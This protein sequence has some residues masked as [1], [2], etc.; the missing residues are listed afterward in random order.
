MKME[1]SPE[2]LYREREKRV[3]DAIQLKVPDRVPIFPHWGLFPAGYSGMT[4]E[5]AYYDIDN[6]LAANKKTN[7]DFAPDL[8]WGPTGGVITPGRVYEAADYKQVKW[9]GHGVSPNHSFQF[10]EGE[11]MKEDEYD[12][13]LYDPSDYA[14]RTYM[15]RVFGTLESLKMLPPVSTLIETYVL[16]PTAVLSLPEVTKAFESLYR[17]GLEA[18]KFAAAMKVFK[19]EMVELGFPLFARTVTLAP[20]DLISDKLRGMR[21]AML[22][23]YRQPDKLL[24]ACEK[25]LPM[26]I[27][28]A[29][30]GTKLYGESTV[31]IPLHRGSDGFMSL[32]QF[33]TFYWPTLKRLILALVEKNLTPCV[34]WEGHW[35]T[36]LEYLAELP[37]GKIMGM[38]DA[39]DLFKAKEI[40]GDTMCISGNMPASLLQTGPPE[41]IK[42]YSKKLIDVVGKGGGFIMSSSTVLDEADPELVRVWFDFTKEYGVYR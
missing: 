41:Q 39:T 33:E 27:R 20:F 19:N 15:P 6:W 22:D 9:P 21:G 38:F 37:K 11:Y 10:V 3:S 4:A 1:K 31:L 5:D 18:A 17:A 14:V 42:E 26:M 16:T 28:T 35:D 13:F 2:E 40:L 32:K 24:E 8:P 30:S 7:I 34:F 29:E 12:A 36:R 25:I 23:M